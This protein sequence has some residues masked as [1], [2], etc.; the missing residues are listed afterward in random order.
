MH[1]TLYTTP[2]AGGKGT[3]WESFAGGEVRS[4]SEGW[5]GPTL[6]FLIYHL[7]RR[8]GY[9]LV[10]HPHPS[11]VFMADFSQKHSQSKKKK[12]MI[13]DPITSVSFYRCV[14]MQ[15]VCLCV[16][17]SLTGPIM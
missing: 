1:V 12:K 15:S 11:A 9:Q 14:N 8:T 17:A 13:S 10:H 4:V 7:T 5:G 2:Y 16:M 6:L 3:V